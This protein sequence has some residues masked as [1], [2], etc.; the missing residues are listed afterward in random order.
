M[1][2]QPPQIEKIS[3]GPTK[4]LEGKPPKPAGGCDRK[5]VYVPLHSLTSLAWPGSNSGCNS[6][7]QASPRNA[8]PISARS[9]ARRLGATLGDRGCTSLGIENGGQRA[10]AYSSMKSTPRAAGFQVLGLAGEERVRPPPTMMNAIFPV[11]R[12]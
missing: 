12:I 6:G 11:F 2:H 7:P 8:R 5:Q 4:K 9:W 3:N 1:T 10:P